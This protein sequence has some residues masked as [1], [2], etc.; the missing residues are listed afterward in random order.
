MFCDSQMLNTTQTNV[1]LSAMK[2]HKGMRPQDIVIL[3]KIIS[4]QDNSWYNKDLAS[5]LGISNSEVSE[6]LNRS[7]IAGLIDDNKRKVE[8]E[9]LLEFLV[10]GLKYV[11]PAMSGRL[12]RGMPTGYSAPVLNDD[13]IVDDPFI[14]P[15]KG[16]RTKGIAIE[17]LYHTVPSACE[18]D[19]LLY[20]L[21]S[22]TDALRIGKS[23]R[24]VIKKLEEKLFS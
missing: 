19:M 7:S 21:L 4:S 17:P 16:K 6:S 10:Y 2:E 18:D 11:F 22:L 3:L 14:W 23:N 13:F 5:A 8:K 1:N 12:L 15:A 9:S 20:D 24:Q